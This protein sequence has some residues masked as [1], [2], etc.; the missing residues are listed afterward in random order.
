MHVK[1]IEPCG[2]ELV[3]LRVAEGQLAE[4]K[5]HASTLP[6][7]QLSERSAC[8]LEVLAT[9]GFSPLDRFMGRLDHERVVSEMRLGNGHLFPVPV[10]LPV[11][12][13][14]AIRQ[15]SVL[16]RVPSNSIV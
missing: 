13:G 12:P 1:L 10:A 3:D 2:G 16:A 15:S 7:L 5:A 11:E 6:S 14:P 8:D 9:G 4:L